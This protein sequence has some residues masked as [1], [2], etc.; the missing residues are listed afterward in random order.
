[1]PKPNTK[2]QTTPKKAQRK[3]HSDV[4][5]KSTSSK[6]KNLNESVCFVYGGKVMKAT[7]VY[8][9]PV[10]SL[11]F[12]E[13]TKEHLVPYYG[14][15]VSCRYV[16]CENAK[17]TFDKV[18][19][20]LKE[21]GYAVENGFNFVKISVATIVPFLRTASGS[22]TVHTFK[23]VAKDDNSSGSKKSKKKKVAND[24][25]AD[26]SD[27]DG[28]DADGSDADGSDAEKSNADDSD[29]DKSGED[30]DESDEETQKA[31]SKKSKKTKTSEDREN[32]KRSKK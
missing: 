16:K 24:S 23:L 4:K 17:E 12:V 27:A 10:D 31:S 18:M 3:S 26:G 1:M 9:Y 22:S 20:S 6:R 13:Y 28:S 19:E 29:V 5:E 14:S 11:D 8:L 25:D 7:T 21:K 15:D 30:H 32:S 2:K